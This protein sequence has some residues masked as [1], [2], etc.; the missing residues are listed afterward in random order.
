MGYDGSIGFAYGVSP[1]GP[2]LTA[3]AGAGAPAGSRHTR[4][5]NTCTEPG[6]A[7]KAVKALADGFI[8]LPNRSD[9]ST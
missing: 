8:E 9:G 3:M 1:L 7:S 2:S 5:D 4:V 6:R